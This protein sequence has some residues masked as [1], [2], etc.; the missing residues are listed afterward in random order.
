MQHSSC[1]ELLL[2]DAAACH[3]ARRWQQLHD[4]RTALANLPAACLRGHLSGTCSQVY[5]HMLHLSH[6]LHS[7]LQTGKPWIAGMQRMQ[8]LTH[9]DT[10]SQFV[11]RVPRV[12]SA[13]YLAGT[14]KSRAP[15]GVDDVKNGVSTSMKFWASRKLRMALVTL[16]LSCR[17]ASML[18]R[19]HARQKVAWEQWVAEPI[20]S[21]AY[22]AISCKGLSHAQ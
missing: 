8:S 13:W 3:G 1:S 14:R 2:D 12:L 15:S 6:M 4:D 21:C 5:I 7:M 19:L 18:G 11:C 9:G 17:F 20:V 16:C 10:S 22:N